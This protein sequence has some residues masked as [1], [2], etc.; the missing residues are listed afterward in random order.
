MREQVGT[1]FGEDGSSQDAFG[2]FINRCRL[3]VIHPHALKALCV[4]LRDRGGHYGRYL[5]LLPKKV[6]SRSAS[7]K[8]Y[9]TQ[10]GKS[11][12]AVDKVGVRFPTDFGVWGGGDWRCSSP[13]DP[14]QIA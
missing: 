8:K 6:L 7:R 10:V 14:T 5:E 3:S 12:G 2:P 1:V 4:N 13:P 11:R 9:G